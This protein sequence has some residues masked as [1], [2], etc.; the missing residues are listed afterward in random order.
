[1]RNKRAA[2][3]GVECRQAHANRAKCTMTDAT[4]AANSDS[5]SSKLPATT[6]ITATVTLKHR[7]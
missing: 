5:S 3:N 1:M 4:E 2:P 6:T 7:P